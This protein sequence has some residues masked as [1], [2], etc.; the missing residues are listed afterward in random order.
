M[1][2]IGVLVSGTGS[3]LQA[4]LDSDLGPAQIA[5]VLSNVS[6]APALERARRADVPTEVV[7]HR[8]VR[9]REAFDAEVVS[10]L[11]AAD[12]EWVVFAGFMRI[13]TPVLLHAFPNQ[14]LNV[15]P[16][17]LPAFP[18]IDA[19]RQALDAGVKVAG[20][21]IHL[22]DSGV[23]TGPIIAQ[24]V[25]PVLADDTED[26]LKKRILEQEHQLLPAVVRSIAE[27]KLHRRGTKV[28]LEGERNR[29]APLWSGI[30]TPQIDRGTEEA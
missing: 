17:L 13:V 30:D 1:T 14:V 4:L 27:G 19:Q 20:C 16:S 5:V 18:G 3:N 12:V 8:A 2:R 10:R 29:S 24:A 6:T 15:H 22:V 7:D 26:T 21:T 28:W 25:V 23:D 11:K 9:P